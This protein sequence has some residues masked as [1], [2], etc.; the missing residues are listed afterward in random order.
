MIELWIG[1]CFVSYP[2]LNPDD[3][4]ERRQTIP[5]RAAFPAEDSPHTKRERYA[6]Y[7][8][9]RHTF[10]NPRIILEAYYMSFVFY[11]FYEAITTSYRI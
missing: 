7:H 4:L 10:I 6:L 8:D 1:E 2:I 11:L 5:K 9:V 3:C